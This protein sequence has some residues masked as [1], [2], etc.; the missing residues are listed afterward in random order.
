MWK[1]ELTVNFPS[2][3]WSLDREDGI[4]HEV[5]AF[6][7]YSYHRKE[8]FGERENF[9]SSFLFNQWDCGTLSFLFLT[10][11]TTETYVS[12]VWLHI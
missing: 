1:M 4:M 5:I 2:S 12:Y 7:M 10:Y 3:V 8:E 9:F 11:A 6:T